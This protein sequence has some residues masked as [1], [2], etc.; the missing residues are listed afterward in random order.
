MQEEQLLEE[1][2]V[3]SSPRKA[4]TSKMGKREARESRPKTNTAEKPQ[5][6]LAMQVELI[7]D[8]AT[9]ISSLLS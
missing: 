9:W 1:V 6:K 5:E 8:F 4:P 2:V 3:F 7:Q